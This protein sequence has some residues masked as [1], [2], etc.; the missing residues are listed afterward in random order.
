MKLETNFM[1]ASAKLRRIALLGV[2]IIALAGLSTAY[3]QELQTPAASRTRSTTGTPLRTA[4]LAAGSGTAN[5]IAKWIDSLGN[6]GNSMLFD[7][8]ARVG[9]GT[10][11]PQT[12]LQVGPGLDVPNMPGATLYVTANG[13]TGIVARDNLNHVELAI[14]TGNLG[15]GQFAGLF[16]T[17]TPQDLYLQSNGNNFM[18]IKTTGAVG[19]GTLTPAA[20]LDVAGGVNVAGN[21]TVAGNIAAKYQDVAEWVSAEESLASGTLV[22]LSPEKSNVVRRSLHAYDT[23]VAGVVSDR[24][25]ILLGEAGESKAKIATTGRVKVHADAS[26]GPIGIGDLLVTSDIPG[27]AMRSN[28]VDLGGV[29]MHRPGT[30]VGKALEP[31]KS[32]KGEILVLLT[33]Q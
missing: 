28:P 14:G 3:A 29:R 27:Y 23:S 9:V 30:I 6:L 5:F 26:A 2:S 21:V 8:G 1:K 33:L 20:L 7:S 18:I 25:G 31:L 11:A 15:G 13:T 4:A 19:I 22:V 24:P 17:R 10:T 32:G 16:G 12:E